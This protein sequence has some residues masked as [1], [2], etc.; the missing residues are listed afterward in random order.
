M[1]AP[2]KTLLL[3]FSYV[4]MPHTWSPSAGYLAASCSMA[5]AVMLLALLVPLE[6]LA[7]WTSRIV[8]V[9]FTLV[10]ASLILIKRKGAPPPEGAFTV[11]VWVPVLGVVTC[12]ALLAAGWL[13]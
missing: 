7:E 10:N 4:L 9:V 13:G 6:N 1:P 12:I 2:S 8:L 3:F 11:R 5:A